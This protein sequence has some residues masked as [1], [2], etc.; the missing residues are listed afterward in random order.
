[1]RALHPTLDEP[2]SDDMSRLKSKGFGS[3][4]QNAF[5]KYVFRTKKAKLID[6][7]LDPNILLHRYSKAQDTDLLEED[8][9]TFGADA[10]GGV[11]YIPPS[12]V[13]T[14]ISMHEIREDKKEDEDVESSPINM[15]P[16]VTAAAPHGQARRQNSIKLM[17]ADALSLPR[18]TTRPADINQTQLQQTGT[19]TTTSVVE[20]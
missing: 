8:I 1:M 2:N 19:S 9:D 17:D 14:S 10:A 6:G 11:L 15:T 7:N 20:D 4:D 3:L 18:A 12:L 5:N 13:N 16:S